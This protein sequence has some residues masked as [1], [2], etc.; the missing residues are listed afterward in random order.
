MKPAFA[1]LILAGCLQPAGSE[2]DGPAAG[3]GDVALIAADNTDDYQGGTLTVV[4]LDD[5]TVCNRVVTATAD[6]VVRVASDDQV[7][8]IG[9]RGF[10][11]LR[12]YDAGQW[13]RPTAE[14]S[15]GAGANPQ[16]A[17]WCGGAWWVTALDSDALLAFDG[18]GQRLSS[19]DLSAYADADGLPELKDLFGDGTTLTASLQRLDRH[20]DPAN[21][22]PAGPGMAVHIDC[23]TGGILG[24]RELPENPTLSH[25]SAGFVATGS[26]RVVQWTWG[27]ETKL[28][29]TLPEQA[30]HSAFVASGHGTVTTVD[31]AGWY[32]LHCVDPE[33]ERTE[34]LATDAYLPAAAGND[35]GE[36]WVAMR[37]SYADP[38]REPTGVPITRATEPGLLVID[39]VICSVIEQVQTRLGPYSLD[40][41]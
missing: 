31:E 39:P 4:D 29:T 23:E 11:R 1:S 24:D 20:T 38:D 27:S 40:F 25:S 35:R 8:E 3:P 14:F 32:R 21:W 12:I 9:R 13:D 26:D 19:V 37:P 30:V 34:L 7:V 10:D 41:Y 36:V 15:V 17:A 18:Q 16:D 2:C 6:S 22:R 5:R 33:G 28:V